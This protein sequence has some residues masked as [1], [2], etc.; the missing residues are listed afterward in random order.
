MAGRLAA[1]SLSAAVPG[2]AAAAGAA[3]LGA[4]PLLVALAALAAAIPAALLA[5][6]TAARPLGRI[7]SALRDGVQGLRDGDYSLRLAVRRD[8]EIGDLVMQYNDIA[9]TLGRER[10]DLRQRELLLDTM[11]EHSAVAI[12]LINAVG[13]VIYGSRAAR[14]L[15]ADGRRL[16]GHALEEILAVCPEA[17]RAALTSERDS[18]VTVALEGADETFHVARRTFTLNARSHALLM[19]R[20]LTPELRRQEVAV[21]K[22][23]IRVIGHELGNSLAPIRSL[24][25]SGRLIR[26]GAGDPSR[27]DDILES[28]EASASR[29][30]RF[31]EGYARVARLP[32]P[33][34]EE[35]DLASFLEQ[36]RRIEPFTL[37]GDAPRRT[38]RIDPAQI[39]QVLLNLAKNARE[40]GSP[41]EEIVVTADVGDDGALTVVVADRGS[42]M[43]ADT[44]AKAM[45]PF[46]SSKHQ[47]TG[48]GLPLCREIVEAHGGTLHL[49]AREGGGVVVTL[50]AP[51]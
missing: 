43:D 5:A 17:M 16:E 18:L 7:A 24:A 35:V 10:N 42:G 11:L 1:L 50:R 40:A 4:S 8:D 49:A 3:A 6:R 13:R 44:M 9:E 21:W 22:K 28:I 29:L 2:A 27:L 38:V 14:L 46:Y 19:I 26:G 48:L 23:V 47:G 45:L 39:Q 25:R 32:D 20:R 33:R 34:R 51:G 30:H 41:S 15:L 37:G 12:L 36:L 31:V